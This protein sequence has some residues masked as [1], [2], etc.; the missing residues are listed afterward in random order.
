MNRDT[1]ADQRGDNIGLEVGEAEDKVRPQIED[2][3]DVAE[4]KAE[5]RGFSRRASG[6]R[7]K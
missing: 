6:G 5:T 4:V 1:L 2:L 7:T 3:R